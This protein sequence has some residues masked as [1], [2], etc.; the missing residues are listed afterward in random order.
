MDRGRTVNASETEPLDRAI[1]L[2][3]LWLDAKATYLAYDFWNDRL[4]GEVTGELRVR[5][6]LP[7]WCSLSSRKAQRPQVLSTDRHVLQGAVELENVSWNAAAQTLEGASLG[8][9]GTAHG[10][11]VYV[12]EAQTWVQ[13]GPFLFQDFPGYTIKMIDEHLLRIRVRFEHATRISWRVDL[14]KL[15]KK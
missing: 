7:A 14:S 2:D 9:K 5:I 11:T 3:R 6:S 13:G 8:P 10:V 1:P 15:L 12:P 4:H